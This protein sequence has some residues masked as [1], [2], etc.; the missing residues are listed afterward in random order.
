MNKQ[1]KLINHIKETY[2]RDITMNQLLNEF[3]FRL[4]LLPSGG[5]VGGLYHYKDNVISISE[6]YWDND[7]W[8][9]FVHEFGH[10]IHHITTKN[11]FYYEYTRRNLLFSDLLKSEQQASLIGLEIWK[12]K[13]PNKVLDD[14]S[15]F[16]KNEIDWLANYY[17][18]YFEIDYDY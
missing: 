4:N 16:K 7:P 17:E 13:F 18:P 8:E 3:G 15:Y 1:I 6:E 14:V 9:V 5:E 10:M 2:P 12:W 11:D